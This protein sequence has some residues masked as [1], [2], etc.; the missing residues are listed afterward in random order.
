MHFVKKIMVM[1][2]DRNRRGYCYLK[3]ATKLLHK[4]NLPNVPSIFFFLFCFVCYGE[5][6]WFHFQVNIG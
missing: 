2:K 3:V 5:A 4:K 6:S 1:D